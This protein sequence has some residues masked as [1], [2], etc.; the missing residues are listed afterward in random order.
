MGLTAQCR[1]EASRRQSF[2]WEATSVLGAAAS[3]GGGT[4]I[5]RETMTWRWAPWATNSCWA[6]GQLGR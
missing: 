3:T 1:R 2:G 4:V 5:G 6:R